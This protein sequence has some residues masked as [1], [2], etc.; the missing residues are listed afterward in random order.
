MMWV[1]NSIV[2]ILV[3]NTIM[4]SILLISMTIGTLKISNPQVVSMHKLSITG[5]HF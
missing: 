3:E 5:K 1:I 4:N 2:I